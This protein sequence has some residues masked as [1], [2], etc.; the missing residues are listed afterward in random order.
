WYK[1]SEYVHLFCHLLLKASHSGFE[2]W[3]NGIGK[4]LLPGQLITGR[5]KLSSETGIN[6]SK[7]ERILKHFEIEQQIEQQK[8]STNRLITITNWNQYQKGEQLFEQRANNG[9]TTTEQRVNT[10][11]EGKEGKKD[12]EGESECNTH[13]IFLNEEIEVFN[14]YKAWI[15]R[16]APRVHQMKEPLTIKQFLS[17]TKKFPAPTGEKVFRKVILE[18][19]D[20]ED[21]YKRRSVFHAMMIWINNEKVDSE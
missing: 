9:R 14:S 17:F 2:T 16:N 8:T 1:K 15:E 13:T 12:K 10:K 19:N 11:Q 5:K 21:L 3:F 7:I 4:K 18:L 6:E 20:Y